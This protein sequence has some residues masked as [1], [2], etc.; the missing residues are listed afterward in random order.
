MQQQKQTSTLPEQVQQ[1][2]QRIAYTDDNINEKVYALYGLTEEENFKKYLVVL[3]QFA[4]YRKQLPPAT[5]KR[6][7]SFPY[8]AGGP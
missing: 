6:N 2:E 8:G 3:Y 1:F 4:N 5:T 7:D